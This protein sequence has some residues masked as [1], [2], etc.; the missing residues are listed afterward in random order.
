MSLFS[1]ED[2][3]RSYH[4]LSVCKD[5]GVNRSAYYVTN[6]DILCDLSRQQLLPV[7]LVSYYV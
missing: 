5:I 2:S 7:D 4:T 1:D 3:N 6:C